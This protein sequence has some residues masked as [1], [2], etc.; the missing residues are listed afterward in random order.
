MLDR[1]NAPLISEINEINFI[2]PQ[3]ISLSEIVP[4]YWLNDVP[5]NT[6]RL[7]FYF[8]AGTAR[9]KSVI[10]SL[11]AG[12]IFS[13]TTEKDST[14]IHN[15]LDD[16]GAYFDVGVT[17]ESALIS[18]YALNDQMLSVFKIFE[19]AFENGI[20]PQK[21]IDELINDRKQKFLVNSEKV[22]FLAQREFQK[23]MFHG[24]PYGNLIELHEYDDINQTELIDF[25]NE[26]YR[27]GLMKV[28]I[29][30]NLPEDH[31]NYIVNNSKRWCVKD[32]PEFVKDFSN[33]PGRITLDK[34]G[35]LQSA[36][37]IGKVLF[38]KKD[39]D[40]LGFSVLNTILGDFFGSRLMKNIREDKGYTYGI[41]SFLSELNKSGY[42]LIGT[43]VG[44]S[45]R[46]E[47][48][49]EIKKEIQVLQTE[50]VSTDELDLVKNYL[51]G[52]VL[53]SADGPYAMMDL[54]LNVETQ[55]MD[56][57]FY[58]AYIQKIKTIQPEELRD[59]ACKYLN[60]ESMSIVTAG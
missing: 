13:G 45:V 21:E 25:F 46:E 41:G 27:N 20:F 11:T 52:Q 31:V 39:S 50:L 5:N 12:L 6:A 47:A 26:F 7:D 9:S 48:I 30:G 42:F 8:N 17:H 51:L 53:K 3:T 60:W 16:H 57:D 40:F 10:A 28:V 49:Q 59:L 2:A 14:V 56:L 34:K 44:A 24:T 54:F 32:Q 38:N 55:G 43:E 35:A 18:F 36:V 33:K 23:N 29:V 4:L 1:K 22:G 37:R 58:N 15:L 19:D